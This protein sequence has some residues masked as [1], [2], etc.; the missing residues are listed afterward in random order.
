[1]KKDVESAKEKYNQLCSKH[2]AL[3]KECKNL[4]TKAT[5]KIEEAQS[6]KIDAGAATKCINDLQECL[7]SSK[8]AHEELA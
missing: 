3:K 1:M 4:K 2:L 5:L 8:V 7:E 6:L